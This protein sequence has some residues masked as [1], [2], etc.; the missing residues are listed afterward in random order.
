LRP[1]KVRDVTGPV[2]VE[3]QVRPFGE[4]GVQTGLAGDHGEDHQ[5]QVV[6]QALAPPLLGTPPGRNAVCE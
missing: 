5:L 2:Q 1:S 6:D 4:D 3:V